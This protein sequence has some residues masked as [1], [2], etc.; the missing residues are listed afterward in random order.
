MKEVWNSGPRLQQLGSDTSQIQRG[1]LKPPQVNNLKTL[2][3]KGSSKCDSDALGSPYANDHMPS[4]PFKQTWNSLDPNDNKNSQCVNTIGQSESSRA[5]GKNQVM[6]THKDSSKLAQEQSLKFAGDLSKS[7][8]S[9]AVSKN[10]SRSFERNNGLITDNQ[11]DSLRQAPGFTSQ[12]ILLPSLDINSQNNDALNFEYANQTTQPKKGLPET[13]HAQKK[14]SQLKLQGNIAFPE[15]SSRGKHTISP[16]GGAVLDINLMERDSKKEAVKGLFNPLKILTPEYSANSETNLNI[17]FDFNAQQELISYDSKEGSFRISAI[18]PV[19]ESSNRSGNQPVPKIK[20]ADTRPNLKR[21]DKRSFLEKEQQ[22][23]GNSRSKV[24]KSFDKNPLYNFKNLKISPETNPRMPKPIMHRAVGYESE[25]EIPHVENFNRQNAL[26]SNNGQ[27]P[28]SAMRIF[29]KQRGEPVCEHIEPALRLPIKLDNSK[30]TYFSGQKGSQAKVRMVDKISLLTRNVGQPQKSTQLKYDSISIEEIGIF[31]RYEV[32]K[33]PYPTHRIIMNNDPRLVE[34]LFNMIQESKGVVSQPG[35]THLAPINEVTEL[36]SCDGETKL[37]MR[38]FYSQTSGVNESGPGNSQKHLSEVSRESGSNQLRMLHS[39]SNPSGIMNIDGEAYLRSSDVLTKQKNQEL[40]KIASAQNSGNWLKPSDNSF[41]GPQESSESAN[42]D[43]ISQDLEIVESNFNNHN[44]HKRIRYK[45]SKAKINPIVDGAGSDFDI[46]KSGFDEQDGYER[47]TKLDFTAR[48]M[49]LKHAEPQKHDKLIS[50]SISKSYAFGSSESIQVFESKLASEKELSN[51]KQE[52]LSQHLIATINQL[53]QKSHERPVEDIKQPSNRIS[54]R[55]QSMKSGSDSKKVPG[56]SPVIKTVEQR[57]TKD[58]KNYGT[59][60]FA[61]PTDTNDA[62]I[63]SSAET[64]RLNR[65]STGQIKGLRFAPER[66]SSAENTQ[67]KVV[68][69]SGKPMT[70]EKKSS[71]PAKHQ[72]ADHYSRMNK[73]ASVLHKLLKIDQK[74]T[75][76]SSQGKNDRIR[77][78]SLSLKYVTTG[79]FLSRK[80]DALKTTNP[81]RPRSKSITEQEPANNVPRES[82]QNLNAQIELK[83][84]RQKLSNLYLRIEKAIFAEGFKQRPQRLKKSTSKDRN[85]VNRKTTEKKLTPDINTRFD[86]KNIFRPKQSLPRNANVYPN[87]FGKYPV[88]RIK[89]REEAELNEHNQQTDQKGPGEQIHAN[90]SNL[91]ISKS[92]T[93]AAMKPSAEEHSKKV[94]WRKITKRALS[95]VQFQRFLQTYPLSDRQIEKT[96]QTFKTL[97]NRQIEVAPVIK[98]SKI[99]LEPTVQSP[100]SFKEHDDA[101][102]GH[103]LTRQESARQ[104]PVISEVNKASFTRPSNAIQ[105]PK[106]YRSSVVNNIPERIVQ[107]YSKSPFIE[108]SR[109][110]MYKA[111]DAVNNQNPK[112]QTQQ[113]R[114]MLDNMPL[115]SPVAIN[116]ATQKSHAPLPIKRPI[117][118]KYQPVNPANKWPA[119]TKLQKPV[120]GP[121]NPYP[122]V[123]TALSVYDMHKLF[124]FFSTLHKKLE[125]S[126]MLQL[127]RLLVEMEALKVISWY[128]GRGQNF[129]VRN[130]EQ[131]QLRIRPLFKMFAQNLD[132]LDFGQFLQSIQAN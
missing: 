22:V 51:K 1:P 69:E 120:P 81:S 132:H 74:F 55:I 17:D 2:L 35:D 38:N 83:N 92:P 4:E 56:G 67:K 100:K 5:E 105:I 90:P 124:N 66:N 96:D 89:E 109:R 77:N 88:S 118:A 12:S 15:V 45:G 99:G 28:N 21:W 11:S 27:L 86:I 121:A 101:K 8:L 25:R 6:G 7:T 37:D 46:S 43:Q 50:K 115:R 65:G 125:A 54:D 93:F 61:E 129:V 52:Q 14:L 84:R 94:G 106:S 19:P 10:E 42:K 57:F 113:G 91:K 123:E 116:Q 97:S 80:L 111:I 13:T 20:Q 18:N 102:K 40:L 31:Y 9:K 70:L 71:L 131:F 48:L 60:D 110:N 62:L 34:S 119:P 130:L 41:R 87:S 64:F 29:T 95:D 26:P 30:T 76:N 104:I 107:K 78:R 114:K 126:F 73:C 59:Y 85:P 39:L 33:Y 24:P 117:V 108:S 127:E 58:V 44:L 98:N 79:S 128:A 36:N 112:L 49:Q 23:L 47:K 68:N 32:P 103:Q 16:Y 82:T 122:L 63:M 53:N 72:S 3:S 75:F